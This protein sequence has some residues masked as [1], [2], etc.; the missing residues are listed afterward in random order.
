MSSFFEEHSVL[1][2]TQ[3]GFQA[4]KSTSHAILDVLTTIY[5]HINNNEYTGLILLN[6]KTAFDTV[7]HSILLYKLEHYGIRGVA[8]KLLKSFLSD[9]LQFVSHHNLSFDILINKFGVPQGSN[10]GPLLFLIYIND[11]PNVLNSNPRLFADDACLNINAVTSS[12]L[13]EK[14]NQ[15]LS[16]VHKWTTANN[17]TVNPEK[18]HCLI[19]P[20]KKTLS[21]SN[22][23]IYFNNSTIKINEA[24][25]YLG[26]TIGNKLNF[27]EHINALA[28]KISRSLGVL[29]KLRHV[30]P[31]SGLRNLYY[32]VIHPHLLY[33]ITVW[34]NAFDKRLKRLTTL[35]NKAVKLISVAQWHDHVTPSYLNVQILKLNDLYSYEVAKLM[36][37]HTRKKLTISLSTFFA[38]V[39][40]MHTR[41]TGL[42]LSELNLYQ[43]RYKSQKLQKRFKYQGVK[44]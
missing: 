26:I 12:V 13:S 5:E 33:K 31:K 27:E 6:F 43:P 14:M 42:A 8:D 32:S 2:K 41:S 15:E 22:I 37:K 23:S 30:L 19:I 36:H 4:S 35:Q 29:G 11:I 39:K 28:T 18:S 34:G 3:Y 38:P 9:R 44:I 17:I 24:V 10:L 25:K 20:P 40:A 7:S 16:T 21:I 1:A